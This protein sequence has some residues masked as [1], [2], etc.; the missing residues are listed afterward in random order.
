M[1]YKTYSQPQRKSTEIGCV[2]CIINVG[3]DFTSIA[4]L[5]K[6][7]DSDHVIIP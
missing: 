4:R 6:V 2:D 3:M 7:A 1:Y 5:Q